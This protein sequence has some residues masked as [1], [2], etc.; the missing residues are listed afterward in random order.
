MEGSPQC[1]ISESFISEKILTTDEHGQT[2]IR[3][4]NSYRDSDLADP[5]LSYPCLSVFI[6]G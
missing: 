1:N 5:Y 4:Q 3:T 6:R 2:R